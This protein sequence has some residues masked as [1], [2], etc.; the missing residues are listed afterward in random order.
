MV[1]GWRSEVNPGTPSTIGSGPQASAAHV[2]NPGPT[3]PALENE[4]QR[5][6]NSNLFWYE[7]WDILFFFLPL[8]LLLCYF[9]ANALTI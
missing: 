8:Y 1:R 5:K 7:I 2:V 9:P 3:S 6:K 4:Q